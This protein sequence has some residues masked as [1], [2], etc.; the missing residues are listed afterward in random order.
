[1]A[2]TL[3]TSL[4]AT[5]RASAIER[6]VPA[7]VRDDA[8]EYIGASEREAEAARVEP[9]CDRVGAL[10]G[11]SPTGGRE[12]GRDSPVSLIPPLGHVLRKKVADPEIGA[13]IE[14]AVMRT[15][16]SATPCSLAPPR[17][18]TRWEWILR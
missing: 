15:L 10:R 17:A 6:V 1:M 3:A 2:V 18:L 11:V 5:V 14:R 12:L 16:A 9:P 13:R 8:K 4:A 7:L